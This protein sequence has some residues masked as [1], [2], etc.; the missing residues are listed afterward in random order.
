MIGFRIRIIGGALLMRHWISRFLRQVVRSIFLLG[1]MFL[2]T[3]MLQVGVLTHYIRIWPECDH[4]QVSA[5]CCLGPS[6]NCTRHHTAWLRGDFLDFS[7]MDNYSTVFKDRTFCP[8]PLCCSPQGRRISLY[9]C[10]SMYVYVCS[11][12]MHHVFNCILRRE[13]NVEC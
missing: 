5:S 6:A 3:S 2:L 8:L 10:I 9:T 7:L 11:S 13:M 12:C 1:L 4:R